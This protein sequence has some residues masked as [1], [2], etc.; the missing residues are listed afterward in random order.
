MVSI[1]KNIENVDKSLLITSSKISSKNLDNIFAELFSLVDMTSIDEENKTLNNTNSIIFSIKNSD[2]FKNNLKEIGKG[3]QLSEQDKI[4][5]NLLSATN[6]DKTNNFINK[7]EAEINAAKSLI[8]VFYTS[9][10]NTNELSTKDTEESSENNQ[11]NHANENIL[12]KINLNI[13]KKKGNLSEKIQKETF[14]KKESLNTEENHEQI[15]TKERKSNDIVNNSMQAVSVKS[16]IK[17]KIDQQKIKVDLILNEEENQNQTKSSLIIQ[18]RVSLSPKLNNKNIEIEQKFIE[19][20]NTNSKNDIK[21][22]PQL[23]NGLSEKS[24]LD[25]MESSWGEKFVKIIKSNISKGIN[26]IDLNLEPNNLGKL[27]IEI[28][29]DGEKTDIKINT[30]NKLASNILNENYQKLNDMLERESLKL[31]TF[32]SMSNGQNNSDKK[33]NQHNQNSGNSLKNKIDSRNIE[34]SEKIEKKTIH[35]VD[36]NA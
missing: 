33:S 21:K 15:L 24:V 23:N 29:V 12:N 5:S 19:E 30:E 16:K 3:E 17:K 22:T 32:S 9:L 20:K 8:S 11:K 36:I 10:K 18:H 26:K 13:K 1:N 7:S 31:N 34:L 14:I 4:S 28:A 25:L 2:F 27:K 6:S 35:S